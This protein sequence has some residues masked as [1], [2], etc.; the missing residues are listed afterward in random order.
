MYDSAY[1][2]RKDT[3][4][5][6]ISMLRNLNAPS[7][8]STNYNVQISELTA[9]GSVIFT[10]IAATDADGVMSFPSP[11]CSHYAV[12]TCFLLF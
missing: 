9:A 3:C 8:N 1:P 12:G 2:D 5:V 6:V 10:G 11:D 7:F 4:T